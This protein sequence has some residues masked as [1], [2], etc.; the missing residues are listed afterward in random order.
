MAR[1]TVAMKKK[2]EF[3]RYAWDIFLRLMTLNAGLTMFLILLVK[4]GLL[5]D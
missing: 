4:M 1:E 5:Q 2:E 3:S